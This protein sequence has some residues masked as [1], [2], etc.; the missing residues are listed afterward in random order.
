MLRAHL[1]LLLFAAMVCMTASQHLPEYGVK[2]TRTIAVT[3]LGQVRLPGIYHIEREASVSDLMKRAMW[4]KSSSGRFVVTRSV[5]G[6]KV[7][8]TTRID[9]PGFRFA[10]GDVVNVPAFYER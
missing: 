4:L 9:D 5:G 7:T 2:D 1:T 3:V 6:K 10:D 8:L